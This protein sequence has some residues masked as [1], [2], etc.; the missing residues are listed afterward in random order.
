[1]LHI[2]LSYH[3]FQFY[4]QF[5]LLCPG[6]L[7]L[8]SQCLICTPIRQAFIKHEAYAMRY[9]V[10]QRSICWKTVNSWPGY[11]PTIPRPSSVNSNSNSF[12]LLQMGLERHHHHHIP[13]SSTFRV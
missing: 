10:S 2:Y 6:V 4:R 8:S 3:L 11:R 1:M 12:H 7:V 13:R 9:P 5:L